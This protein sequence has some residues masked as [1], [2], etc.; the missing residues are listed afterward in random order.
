MANTENCCASSYLQFIWK[1]MHSDISTITSARA[2]IYGL[3]VM[4]RF[5]FYLTLH[6]PTIPTLPYPRQIYKLLNFYLAI[7]LKYERN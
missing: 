4:F 7:D 2:N 1:S 6:Q 5:S 3:C